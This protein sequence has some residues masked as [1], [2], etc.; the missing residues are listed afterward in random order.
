[1]SRSI[2][3]QRADEDISFV[4]ALGVSYHRISLRYSGARVIVQID[5]RWVSVHT[6]LSG[7]VISRWLG[8]GTDFDPDPPGRS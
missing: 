1:M 3:S 8:Y 7:I 4:R 2:Q 5:G 6:N